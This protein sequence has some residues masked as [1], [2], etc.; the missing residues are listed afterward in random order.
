MFSDDNSVTLE[1]MVAF[2]FTPVTEGHIY[3]EFRLAKDLKDFRYLY[4]L[5]DSTIA[6]KMDFIIDN[7]VEISEDEYYNTNIN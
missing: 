5:H 3:T 4:S 7:V 1:N 6:S 2:E